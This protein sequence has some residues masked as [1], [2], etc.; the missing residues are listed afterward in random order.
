MPS[1]TFFLYQLLFVAMM[2]AVEVVKRTTSINVEWSRKATHL[3]CSLGS[4][5]FVLYL[6]PYEVLLTVIVFTV[7]LI[8]SKSTGILTS[9]HNVPRTTYGEIIF[10]IAVGLGALFYHPD[11]PYAQTDSVL[12]YIYGILI[13]GLA[14]LAA[15]LVGHGIPSPIMPLS[16]RKTLAGTSAF[17]LVAAIVGIAMGIPIPEAILY[18]GILAFIELVVPYGFDNLFIPALGAYL[19]VFSMH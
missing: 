9:V 15:N 12:P 10:P 5:G 14:D 18:A 13:M 8:V 19:M 1:L 16:K 6:T 17:F 3:L 7:A 4:V 2:G 11:S